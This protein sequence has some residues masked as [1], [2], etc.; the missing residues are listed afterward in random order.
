[1]SDETSICKHCGRGI[2]ANDAVSPIGGKVWPY[3]HIGGNAT[4]QRPP[5]LAEP[6]GGL[7]AHDREVTAKAFMDAADEY[8]GTVSVVQ[9][10]YWLRARA[11]ALGIP[12]GTEKEG[13]N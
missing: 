7:A 3:K 5:T 10:R 9:F 12:E 1:M 2:T 4:C 8:P 6:D 13:K 11:A